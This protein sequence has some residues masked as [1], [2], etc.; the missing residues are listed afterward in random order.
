MTRF[1]R[2]ALCFLALPLAL[3]AVSFSEDRRLEENA[4]DSFTF[5]V[6]LDD[7]VLIQVRDGAV[8]L[9]GTV[10]DDAAKALAADTVANLA[11]DALIRNDLAV[12]PRH[13]AASDAGLAD[14]IRGVLLVRANVSAAST[15]VTVDASVATLTGSASSLAQKELTGRYA[16]AVP[17][18]TSVRNDLVV[19]LRPPAQPGDERIDDASIT[20]QVKLALGGR[21]TAIRTKD[22]VVQLTGPAATAADRDAATRLAA[23][24]R[25]VVSVENAM[26]LPQL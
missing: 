23:D 6:L 5:Q 4:R 26:T 8:T 17:G 9:T 2:P 13:A 18:V 3:G 1:A 15:T 25:G 10:D 14:R 21:A 19:H 24:V 16:A 12:K 20:S 7:A 22:Q 11:A